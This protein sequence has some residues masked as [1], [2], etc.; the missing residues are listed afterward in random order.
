ME[1]L[2]IILEIIVKEF[3]NIFIKY[4]TTT[5]KQQLKNDYEQGNRIGNTITKFLAGLCVTFAIGFTIVVLIGNVPKANSIFCVVS[6]LVY[7][8]VFLMFSYSFIPH[9]KIQF[10]KLQ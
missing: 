6:F 2:K 8:F 5:P 10:I 1:Q 3:I 4:I 9:K 7:A